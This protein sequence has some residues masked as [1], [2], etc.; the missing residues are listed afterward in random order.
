MIGQLFKTEYCVLISIILLLTYFLIV[1]L[2]RF[3][4]YKVSEDNNHTLSKKAYKHLY[5]I[6]ST[7]VTMFLCLVMVS[8]WLGLITGGIL[9]LFFISSVFIQ[10]AFIKKN[11]DFYRIYEI[12]K[13]YECDVNDYIEVDNYKGKIVSFNLYH[14]ELLD[15][16]GNYTYLKGSSITNL[17]NNS[18]NV[19][20]V[21][22]NVMIDGDKKVDDIKEL[23]EK[24]LPSL[25]KDY[26]IILEG[27]N[28]DGVGEI[29]K[30]SYSI[31]LSTKVKYEDIDKA[32]AVIQTKVMEVLCKR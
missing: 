18:K 14:L 30:D 5:F 27:P 32:K 2:V 26:P 10:Y 17:I 3:I 23:F 20:D 11:K 9:S 15:N 28:F 1:G 4:T 24:E 13:N 12:V 8:I 7:Y 22:I 6:I 21:K 29:D 16:S 25:V 19:Y 31:I